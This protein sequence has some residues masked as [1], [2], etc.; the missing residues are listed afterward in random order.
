MEITREE[1]QLRKMG[2]FCSFQPIGWSFAFFFFF[3]PHPRHVE[4]PKP[5]IEIEPQQLQ[6]G[7]LNLMI[8]Q[9]TPPLSSSFLFFISH[10]PHVFPHPVSLSLGTMWLHVPTLMAG[11]LCFYIL[12]FESSS[13]PMTGGR[14][15]LSLDVWRDVMSKPMTAR[16]TA[17]LGFTRKFLWTLSHLLSGI[18]PCR[19]ERTWKGILFML[20]HCPQFA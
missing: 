13:C 18:L 2:T 9:G 4:F 3:W 16:P 20:P 17:F 8:H 1:S 11:W 7:V 5:R 6:C 19:G 14:H 12:N 10:C 15:E